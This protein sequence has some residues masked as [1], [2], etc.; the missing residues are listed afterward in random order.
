MA[1]GDDGALPAQEDRSS[2]K[3]KAEEQFGPDS[4]KTK[5]DHPTTPTNVNPPKR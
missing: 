4:K 2:I 1:D 5:S 3:R